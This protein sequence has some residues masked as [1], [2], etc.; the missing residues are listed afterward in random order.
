MENRKDQEIDLL[1]LLARFFEAI[2]QNW[3]VFLVLI[4]ISVAFCL[5]ISSLTKANYRSSMLILTALLNEKE[6]EFIFEQLNKADTFPGLD[7]DTKKRVLGITSKVLPTNTDPTLKQVYIEVTARVSDISAFRPLQ[8]SLID[9][10][11]QTEPVLRKRYERIQFDSAMIQRIDNELAAMDEV[12]QN[13]PVTNK[14]YIDPSQ[15]YAKSVE[16]FQERLEYIQDMR[17]VSTIKVIKGFESLAADTK[18]PKVFV[19]LIGIVAGFFAFAFFL[20]V[21]TFYEY[22]RKTRANDPAF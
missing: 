22:Y 13:V 18:M 5:Y 19:V 20:A 14:D 4:T 8:Q 6:S 16:L 2:R 21:K 7:S 15:L 3:I 12:K 11:D 17:E 10:L 1:N 9:Y